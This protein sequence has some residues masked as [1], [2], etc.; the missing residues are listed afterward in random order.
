MV[1]NCGACKIK[2]A[3]VLV[4]SGS[5]AW[6]GGHA[7]GPEDDEVLRM[8]DRMIWTVTVARGGPRQWLWLW[9]AN[10]AAYHSHVFRLL[11]TGDSGGE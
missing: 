8:R 11:R 10:T 2:V 4:L 3:N 9:L 6:G 1:A 7:L 5:G